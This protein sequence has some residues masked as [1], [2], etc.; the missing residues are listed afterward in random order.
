MK[1][2]NLS[3]VAIFTLLLAVACTPAATT[4]PGGSPG[5]SP[6]GSP[7]G[8]PGDSGPPITATDTVTIGPDEPILIGTLLVLTTADADLGLDSQYG[9][10][11]A[12]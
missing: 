8:S 5:G 12:A 3:A 2:R 10:R 6:A 7:A 9:V 11:V 4:G 1:L